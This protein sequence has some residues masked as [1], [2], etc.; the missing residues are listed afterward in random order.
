VRWLDIQKGGDLAASPLIQFCSQ[1]FDTAQHAAGFCG[2]DVYESRAPI[3][4]RMHERGVNLVAVARMS[5][6]IDTLVV[7]VIRSD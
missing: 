3:F 2:V 5:Q 1:P 4:E 7:A 6:V